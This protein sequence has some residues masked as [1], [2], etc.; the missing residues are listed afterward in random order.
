MNHVIHYVKNRYLRRRRSRFHVGLRTIKTV[1]AVF[2]SML[3]VEIYGTSTSKLIFAML[4]AM[5]AVQPTFVESLESCVSQLFGVFCG[6]LV[7]VILFLT[8]LSHLAGTV[9]GMTIVITLYNAM[10]L[11]FSPSLPCFV[12]VLIC[13]TPDI[14]P[15][16]YALERMWDTAIGLGV[17]MVINTLIFPYDNRW[18]IR[19]TM[20]SLDQEVILFLNDMFDGDENRPDS[21]ALAAKIGDIYQQL[22]VFSKQF[23]FIRPKRRKSQLN[24]VREYVQTARHLASHMEVLCHVYPIGRLSEENCRRLADAGAQINVSACRNADPRQDK[25]TNYHVEQILKLREELLDLLHDL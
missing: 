1:A 5:A 10:H 15:L 17:G 22:N 9:I 19:S 18:Q 25:I 4:G 21:D 6:S 13:T 16:I 3:L 20:K 7:G 8:P 24:G 2:V 14:Q 23:L 12:V 11:R